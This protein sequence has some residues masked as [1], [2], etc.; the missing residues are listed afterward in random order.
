MGHRT[1]IG[2]LSDGERKRLATLI[3]E[4]LTLAVIDNHR[5]VNHMEQF[6]AHHR[7]YIFG[8]ETFLKRRIT[9][10]AFRDKVVPLPFW[11]SRMPLPSH[12]NTFEGGPAVAPNRAWTRPALPGP[13]APPAPPPPF[14]SVSRVRAYLRALANYDDA[15]KQ[16]TLDVRAV[17]LLNPPV[18]DTNY[19]NTAY[20]GKAFPVASGLNNPENFEDAHDLCAAHRNG[21]GLGMDILE[22]LTVTATH[23]H[24]ITHSSLAGLDTPV[25]ETDLINYVVNFPSISNI[26]TIGPFMNGGNTAAPFIFWP[27]HA[28]FDTFYY[29]WEQAHLRPLESPCTVPNSRLTGELELF[30]VG[31]D[32][33]IW[34][35]CAAGDG[36][37]N[38]DNGRFGNWEHWHRVHT[39][40]T[41]RRMTVV[42]NES[43][44]IELFGISN[45]ANASLVHTQMLDN[46]C[47]HWSSWED[48]GGSNREL[49]VVA[50]PE[51]VLAVFA[52]HIDGAIW[53]RK[54]GRTGG[55]SSWDQL[56][57]V[58]QSK[59]AAIIDGNSPSSRIH[60]FSLGNGYVWHRWEQAARGAWVGPTEHI[61]VDFGKRF[62]D[63]T[64]ARNKDKRLEVFA[65]GT[66]KKVYHAWQTSAGANNSF[67]PWELLHHSDTDDIAVGSNKDGR[68]EIFMC[69]GGTVRHKWQVAPNS[70]WTSNAEA[71]PLDKPMGSLK[72]PFTAKDKD[73]RLMVFGVAD[74]GLLWHAWQNAPNQG[75]WIGWLVI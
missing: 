3:K 62:T 31:K 59:V 44:G 75:P 64:V 53:F 13:P 38:T 68:L 58:N 17:I 20:P 7:A 72:N 12:F 32:G 35:C 5:K 52:I 42:A 25:D 67:S 60:V 46:K 8:L 23:Y 47:K 49:A 26:G 18:T 45:D 41:L 56:F 40:Q 43:G 22:G 30:E 71:I 54:K 6:F 36:G 61:V 33:I 9:D 48:L 1:D 50:A 55:W 29:T 39:G 10:A 15:L 4:F 69:G 74:D 37:P 70:G 51:G 24:G 66:D 73:G 19:L 21:R 11:D 14:S 63:F 34:H 57:D 27:L 2:T 28:F 65:I 16:W